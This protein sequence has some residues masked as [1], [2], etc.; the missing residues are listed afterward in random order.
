MPAGNLSPAAVQCDSATW[1]TGLT[2]P[3]QIGGRA[4]AYGDIHL[5]RRT[6]THGQPQQMFG[7][8]PAAA[9]RRN[10]V[11]TAVMDCKTVTQQSLLRH[12]SGVTAGSLIGGHKSKRFKSVRCSCYKVWQVGRS[13][14]PPFIPG[15]FCVSHGSRH[16]LNTHS[17]QKRQTIY[18]AIIRKPASQ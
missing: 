13:F 6:H 1:R 9:P 16:T 5:T 3:R 11:K 17:H 4:C 2:E 7:R 8:S 12:A 18:T 14:V 10:A 15:K